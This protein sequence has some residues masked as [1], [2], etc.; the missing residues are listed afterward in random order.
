[1][2]AICL[3]QRKIGVDDVYTACAKIE[4]Q[5]EYTKFLARAR[6]ISDGP[7]RKEYSFLF[8]DVYHTPQEWKS[9]EAMIN[10]PDL[11]EFLKSKDNQKV[12]PKAF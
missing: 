1:M 12:R 8:W 4:N 11:K 7:D 5:I 10:I 2:E 3:Y 9:M 6:E